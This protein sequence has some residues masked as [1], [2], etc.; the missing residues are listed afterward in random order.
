[1]ADLIFGVPNLV[2]FRV[3]FTTRVGRECNVA[4]EACS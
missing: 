1:L 2:H 3:H 4:R